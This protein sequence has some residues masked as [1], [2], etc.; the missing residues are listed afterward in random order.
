VVAKQE[1]A[2]TIADVS[3]LKVPLLL[4]HAPA[5][6]LED[7]MLVQPLVQ[8]LALLGRPTQVLEHTAHLLSTTYVLLEQ[9]L[10]EDAMY[11]V[12]AV[13]DHIQVVLQEQLVLILQVT[14][15]LVVAHKVAEYAAAHLL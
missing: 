2:V 13:L 10:V 4:E 12:A 15:A 3:P 1:L 5:L 11:Q 14:L 9:P 6:Q 7:P 8:E